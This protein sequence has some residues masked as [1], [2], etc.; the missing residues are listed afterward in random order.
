MYISNIGFVKM[1]VEDNE[2]S[3]LKGAQETFRISGWPTI[4]FESNREN[5]DLFDY[6]RDEMGYTIISISGVSNMFLA[7]YKN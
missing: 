7:T 3:V 2:L 1:D 4:L 6:V 5:G